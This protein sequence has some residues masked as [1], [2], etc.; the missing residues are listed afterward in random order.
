[1]SRRLQS[2]QK[3]AIFLSLGISLLIIAATCVET[4]WRHHNSTQATVEDPLI[5]PPD[6]PRHLVDFSLVD[7]NGHPVT[8]WD[9]KDKIAVVSFVFAS[10]SVVCP[11]VS[12]QMAQIQRQTTNDS[13]VRLVS[14]TVDPTDDTPDVLARYAQKYGADSGRWSFLTGEEAQMQHLI[15]ESFLARDTE[16]N[17]SFM[18]GN[19]ENSQRIVLVNQRGDIVKY[20]DGLNLDAAHAVMLEI[21]K[22]KRSSR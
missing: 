10:C 22:L 8:R 16:T 3:R 9:L 4:I 21:G 12:E 6:H 19:Y 18:P 2:A 7:Q 5:I 1:V 17:L 13:Q 11:Y 20:F 15:S 14:L